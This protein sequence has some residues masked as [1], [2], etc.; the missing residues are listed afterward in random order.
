MMIPD[1]NPRTDFVPAEEMV[2]EDLKTLKVLSDPLRLRIRELMTHPTT[3]KQVAAELNIPATK[4]YYHIDQLEKHGLIVLVDTRIVSGIIEK[5]YQIAARQVRVA[6]HLLSPEA[7]ESEKGLSITVKGLFEDTRDDLLTSL[8]S[9][10]AS[11]EEDAPLHNSM[12]VS[13]MRLLLK[14][15]EA[16]ALYRRLRELFEEY[17]LLSRA[18]ETDGSDDA[19]YYKLLLTLFP[20]SRK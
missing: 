16:D 10:T 9:G 6:R 13:T 12:I 7:G 18:H 20:S 8:N 2:I 5:H 15:D 3:V 17:R 4:L 19:R 11:L 1:L 14:E